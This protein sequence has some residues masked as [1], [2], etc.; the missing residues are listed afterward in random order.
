MVDDIGDRMPH[1]VEYSSYLEGVSIKDV[2][3]AK[4]DALPVLVNDSP[5]GVDDMLDRPQ[6]AV[7]YSTYM[8]DER[9]P[10]WYEQR[11]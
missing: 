6:F 10:G 4:S 7:E 9:Y 8:E 2:K 11:K 3:R 1:T 5:M